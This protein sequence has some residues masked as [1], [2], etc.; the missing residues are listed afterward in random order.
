MR[1]FIAVAASVALVLALSATPAFAHEKRTVGPNTFLVGFLVEPT[2][3]GAPNG[4]S[5][6]VTETATRAPVE[7]LQDTLKVEIT[8]AGQS[9][10]RSFHEVEDEPGAYAADFVPTSTSTY[11]FRIFGKVG[12][13]DM[14]ERFESGPNTFDEP[15]NIRDAQFPPVPDLG[16]A[17]DQTR[18][19]AIAALVVGI[20]GLGVSLMRRRA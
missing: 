6:T 4:V 12:T 16:S 3:T 1:R 20:A 8:V 2:Y 11:V 18:L 7:G 13:L 15:T 10:T 14:N 9:E 5:L 19:I 17:V